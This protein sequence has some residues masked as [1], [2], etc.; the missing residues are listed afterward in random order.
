M[1]ATP[2][3]AALRRRDPGRRKPD[4]A[5]L[6]RNP[7]LA[8]VDVGPWT[9]ETPK[10]PTAGPRPAANQV[11]P[12][13]G[14]APLA[15]PNSACLGSTWRARA[16]LPGYEWSST[17]GPSL[18][19]SRGDP[20]RRLTAWVPPCSRSVQRKPGTDRASVSQAAA[21]RGA[22]PLPAMSLG[23]YTCRLGKRRRESRRSAGQPFRDWA[24]VGPGA[25]GRG[26]WS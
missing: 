5:C 2:T 21:C 9:L 11:P 12:G 6:G 15:L 4:G 26:C 14:P 8:V 23:A 7:L 10:P 18:Q 25:R 17:F 20:V 13:P 1:R 24:H 16:T 3:C 19:A 22:P